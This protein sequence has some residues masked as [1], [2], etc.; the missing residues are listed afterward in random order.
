MATVKIAY[1]RNGKH[2]IPS[3]ARDLKIPLHIIL[4]FPEESVPTGKFFEFVHVEIYWIML[5]KY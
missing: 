4:P 2:F 1:Q 3:L 5:S